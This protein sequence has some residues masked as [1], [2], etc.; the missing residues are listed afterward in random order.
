MFHKLF[1]RRGA[2]AV[3]AVAFGVSGLTLAT[4]GTAGATTSVIGGSG[5]NTIYQLDIGLGDLFSQAPGCNLA[6]SPQP[7]DFS[8]AT[9]YATGTTVNQPGEDGETATK[10]NPY[11]DVVFQYPALGSGNGVHQLQGNSGTGT[12]EPAISYARSSASPANS[13]GTA[14]Q[15]YVQFAID[16]VS[17]VHFV[18]DSTGTALPTAKAVNM[19]LTQLQKVYNDTLTCKKNGVTY[20][21]DWICLGAPTSLHIDCYMAQNG[22]G[23]EGTWAQYVTAGSS[24]PACLN[25]EASGTAASHNGLFENEVSSITSP[26][27]AYYNNDVNQALYFFSYG[28]YSVECKKNLCPGA[29]GY[30][31]A[32]GKIGGIAATKASIQGAGGANH[33]NFPIIRYLSN[34][35][36]NST[37]T[38]APGTAAAPASQA[39]LNFMSEYGFLCKPS[40]ATDIDPYTGLNYRYEIETTLIQNGFFPIDVGYN[41]STQQA[42]A[43]FSEGTLSNPAVIT[44]PAFQLVDTQ[45]NLANPSGY[46]LPID[47]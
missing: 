11:N 18:K 40:T 1:S 38:G 33:G 14:T 41:A 16:G 7:L 35:Y 37:A 30:T 4:A 22:S 13:H 25:D 44:D 26:G 34:V 47:G 29:Q 6:G 20:K 42:G 3:A 32:L 10:E 21:M 36:N 45:Y 28:K 23:T 2:A 17:W 43:P 15:N 12:G 8:C 19:G 9:P 39:T 31:T 46:C 24:T 27:S 5:S